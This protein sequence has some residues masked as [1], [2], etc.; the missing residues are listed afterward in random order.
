MNQT[1]VKLYDLPDS[2]FSTGG[3]IAEKI[4]AAGFCDG[5]VAV[6]GQN[7]WW[8]LTEVELDANLKP[9]EQL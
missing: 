9:A 6:I 8:N 5:A 2:E 1:E 4:E 7:H 3:R